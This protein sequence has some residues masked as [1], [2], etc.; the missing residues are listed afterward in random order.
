M[1][2]AGSDAPAEETIGQPLPRTNKS[3]KE[4]AKSDCVPMS[5]TQTMEGPSH[6]AMRSAAHVLGAFCSLFSHPI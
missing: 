1:G 5:L 4:K 6:A 2:T 3:E